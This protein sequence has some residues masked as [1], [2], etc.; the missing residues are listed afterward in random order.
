M[1]LPRMFAENS[2]RPLLRNELL[3]AP[4]PMLPSPTAVRKDRQASTK[5]H[6]FIWEVFPPPPLRSPVSCFAPACLYWFSLPF[7]LRFVS[8]VFSLVCPPDRSSLSPP[9]RRPPRVTCAARLPISG[10]AV[11]G[12]AL[13]GG[14]TDWVRAAA[15]GLAARVI[16]FL[17]SGGVR[18]SAVALVDA[19][20]RRPRGSG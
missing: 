12:S 11:S 18:R 13:S 9:R 3:L 16:R 15:P 1:R 7:S 14:T 8:C 19:Y 6:A 2:S 17:Q 10:R 20:W 5:P 4:S